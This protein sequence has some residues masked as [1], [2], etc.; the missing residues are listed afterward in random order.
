LPTNSD[1]LLPYPYLVAIRV[2]YS[3]LWQA[4]YLLQLKYRRYTTQE[5]VIGWHIQRAYKFTFCA[6]SILFTVRTT[7]P[8][9]MLRNNTMPLGIA[10]VVTISAGSNFCKVLR[11]ACMQSDQVFYDQLQRS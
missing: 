9:M 1:T 5:S 3:F 8:F 7:G 6:L 4:T 2:Q 10:T 11:N